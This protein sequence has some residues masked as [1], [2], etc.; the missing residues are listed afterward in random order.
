MKRT[1]LK[2]SAP[3]KRRTAL[4]SVNRARQDK[5]R[6]EYRKYLA[7]PQWKAKRAEAMERAG[8]RCEF[9]GYRFAVGDFGPLR[10]LWTTYRCE[11]TTGLHCHHTRYPR[12]LGAESVDTLQV[13]CKHHHEL[14]ESKKWWRRE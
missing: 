10:D 6:A 13:L 3:M 8:H 5:R 4:R 2:R 14:E 1:A 12:T 7:S 9:E 11:E